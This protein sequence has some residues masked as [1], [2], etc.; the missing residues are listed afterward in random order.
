MASKNRWVFHQGI[1]WT[2][3]LNEMHASPFGARIPASFGRVHEGMV[4]QLLR[5]TRQMDPIAPE[6]I[7]RRFEMGS[8]CFVARVDGSI[9]AYGWLTRGPEWIGEF[10]RQLLIPED[11]AYIWD[12]ATLPAFR[13][14]RFFSALL[15]HIVDQ[16]KQ[17]G[18]QR[19]WIISVRVVPA[20]ARGLEAAGFQPLVSLSYLRIIDRH[21][22]LATPQKGVT[23]RQLASAR[24]LLKRDS[25][26]A[27]GRLLAGN[28]SRPTLPDTH[29]D[30]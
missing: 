6:A 10:E 19:L 27:Y 21:L 22:L 14:Q 18:V 4:P 1:L 28:S 16:L 15:G 24:H 17:E 30:G 9:V 23:A 20:L 11:E 5:A 29:F 3:E 8:Q 25:E 13:R 12:C 2:A 7:W 26:K